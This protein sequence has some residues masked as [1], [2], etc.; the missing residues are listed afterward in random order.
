MINTDERKGGWKQKI[1]HEAIE[2]GINFIYMAFIFAALEWYRRLILVEY[3]ISYLH[4]GIALIKAAVLA[5]VVMAGDILRLGRGLEDKPLI[6]PALY[7]AFVF[8]VW[9]GIF[10]VFEHTIGGFL[11]GKGLT[12]GFYELMSMGGYELFAKCLVTFFAFV[13]FF[14]FKELGRV[15]GEGK[16]RAMLFRRRVG[17][18]SDRSSLG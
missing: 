1:V 2:Y 7:K 12:E 14:A 3:Q 11:H 10:G 6:F 8:T 16:I 13:P 18:Q 17:A 4:Y 5:K 15:L 9:V